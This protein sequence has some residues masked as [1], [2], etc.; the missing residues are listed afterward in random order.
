MGGQINRGTEFGEIIYQLACNRNFNTYVEIG[1]WNGQGSTKCFIDGLFSRDDISKLISLETDPKFYKQAKD[2]WK[3]QSLVYKNLSKKLILI[4]GRIVEND[5]IFDEK[6]IQNFNKPLYSD[7]QYYQWLDNDKENY[8]LC[9][10]ILDKIPSNID[11]LLLDGGEFSTYKEFLIL[12]DR[13]KIIL[14][15]DTK[16]LKCEKVVVDLESSDEWVCAHSS[17][18]RNGWA[19]YEKK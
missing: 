12:K 6:D 9:E 18:S 14:L 16:E 1:T 8:R 13:A 11:V 7:E 4:H 17:N 10:N 2:Y 3:M 15:D 19:V 5:E